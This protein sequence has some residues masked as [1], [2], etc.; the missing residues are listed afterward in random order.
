MKNGYSFDTINNT[1]TISSTFVK[2]ASRIGSPEYNLILKARREFPD[3]TILQA[4][5]K[6][7]KKSITFAQMEAFIGMHRDASERMKTFEKVK[8][9]S[10][11][12]SNPYQYVKTWFEKA[13]PYF[14]QQPVLDTDGFLVDGTQAQDSKTATDNIT[15]IDGAA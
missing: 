6:E 11:I 14:T 2:K 12:Q 3:L 8:V 4:E 9:L 10:R 13:Y 5:K 15:A 1:L 7:G